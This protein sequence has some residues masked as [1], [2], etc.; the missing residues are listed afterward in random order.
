MYIRKLF[1]IWSQE[2]CFPLAL[3]IYPVTQQFFFYFRVYFRCVVVFSIHDAFSEH[4]FKS[5][6]YQSET[7][8]IGTHKQHH[9]VLKAVLS[10]R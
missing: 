2:S 5:E 7:F 1:I 6:Y 10:A 3:L 4:V 9:T 8:L